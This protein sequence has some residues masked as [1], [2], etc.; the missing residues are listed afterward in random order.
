MKEINDS[1]LWNS[2]SSI[3]SPLASNPHLN[4]R[5]AAF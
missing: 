2:N 3:V 1:L 5:K 4:V